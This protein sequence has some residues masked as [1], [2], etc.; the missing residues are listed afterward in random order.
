MKYV[1]CRDLGKECDYVAEGNSDEEVIQ[2][3]GEHGKNVHGM[4]DE[5]FTDELIELARSKIRDREESVE[6]A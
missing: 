1:T 6:A 3:L 4:K 2:K 5:D